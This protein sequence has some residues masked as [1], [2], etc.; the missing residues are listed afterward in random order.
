LSAIRRVEDIQDHLRQTR[1]RRVLDLHYE[2]LTSD[3]QTI[4]D[5]QLRSLAEFVTGSCDADLLA[6]L[7]ETR[8]TGHGP[9]PFGKSRGRAER[10]RD[11]QRN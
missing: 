4:S 2:L 3:D 8:A 11:D 7:R 6:S 10:R 5:G 1:P 9:F